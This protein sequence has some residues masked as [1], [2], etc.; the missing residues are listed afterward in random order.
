MWRRRPWFTLE[1]LPPSSES[2][3]WCVVKQSSGCSMV[4]SS[5]S[6]NS[7]GLSA[8]AA[9]GILKQELKACPPKQ[10]CKP[11]RAHAPRQLCKRTLRAHPARQLRRH[12]AA[13]TPHHD[14]NVVMGARCPHPNGTNMAMG[15]HCPRQSGT[16]LGMGARFARLSGAPLW[17]GTRLCHPSS[18]LL[19]VGAQLPH[20]MLA[21]SPLQSGAVLMTRARFIHSPRR[22]GAAVATET[23]SPRR[24][25]ECS[26]KRRRACGKCR[27]LLGNSHGTVSVIIQ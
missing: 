23:C 25:A 24:S 22:K 17:T 21:W 15:A 27:P 9:E 3:L 4:S 19:E 14:R 20:R 5:S 26:L 8:L 18:V 10:T 7:G 2:S 1:S 6:S 16:P 11:L 13:C 12:C